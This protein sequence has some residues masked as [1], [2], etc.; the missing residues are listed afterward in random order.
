MKELMEQGHEV[1][2]FEASMGTGGVYRS[3]YGA[4]RLTSSNLTTSFGS[5]SDGKEAQP[6]IWNRDEYLAYLDAYAKRFNLYEN[7]RLGTFVTRVEPLPQ[8]KCWFRRSGLR[9]HLLRR[10]FR[11]ENA[12]FSRPRDI[13]WPYPA[14][15]DFFERGKSGGGN[16]S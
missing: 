4:L 3:H 13:R 5:Y 14:L 6:V 12:S 9:R 15:L 10:S 16:A 1:F 2:A 11:A 8:T 7:L